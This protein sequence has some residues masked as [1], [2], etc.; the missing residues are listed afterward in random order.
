MKGESYEDRE[1]RKAIQAEMEKIVD[2]HVVQ[3]AE[4]FDAVRIICVGKTGDDMW[5]AYSRGRGNWF[6]QYGSVRDWLLRQEKAD[7]EDDEDGDD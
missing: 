3:L 6:A 4:H 7:E 5:G 1:E 2:A